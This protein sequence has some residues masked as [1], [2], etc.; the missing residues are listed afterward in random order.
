[1]TA[2]DTRGLRGEAGVGVVELIVYIALAALVST[3]IVT[4]FVTG[5]QSEAGTRQ[6]DAATS[7]AQLVSNSVQKSIRN[8]SG[9]DVTGS[10]LRAK[11]A[12]GSGT[13]WQCEA[14]RLTS[15]GEL[16]YKT[17][18]SLITA[19]E[20]GWGTL[21][22]GVSGTV[23]PDQPFERDG[24]RLQLRLQVVVGAATAQVGAAVTAQA[25]GEGGTSCW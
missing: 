2:R 24:N 21:A 15:A 20:G 10:L 4:V 12:V 19:T 22:T 1:M 9:F 16:Q 11:V 13:G 7:A 6:R 5:L 18:S 8:S 3:T 23:V 14:W 25:F 17:S